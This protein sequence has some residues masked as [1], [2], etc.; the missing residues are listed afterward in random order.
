MIVLCWLWLQLLYNRQELFP[1]RDVDSNREETQ[2]HIKSIL[3]QQ[4]DALGPM[5]WQQGTIIVLFTILVI[6]W[7]TRDFSHIGG[8]SILF[9]KGYVTPSIYS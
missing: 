7:I 6:L 1:C 5:N 9:R 4:Y 3:K 2:N 8:W